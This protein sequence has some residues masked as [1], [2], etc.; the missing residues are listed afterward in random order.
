VNRLAERI[1]RLIAAGGPVPLAD[2][3]HLCL[4][5]PADGYYARLENIGA[6]GDFVT[7]PEISPLFGE[8][9]AVWCVAAWQALGSPARFALVE[10]GP[11]SGALM[12]DVLRASRRFAG[13]HDA[14]A[15]HLVETGPL[16]RERQRLRLSGLHPRIAWVA[17]LAALP[18]EPL[19]FFANEFLDALPV[20]QFVKSGGAWRERCIGLDDKGALAW[21]LGPR[22]ADALPA[23]HETEAEG[24]VFEHAPAREAFA[25]T[26]ARRLAS[27]GGAALLIDYGHA[28][29]GFGD[30]FQ[31]VAGHKFADPL[32][33]PGH[34]DLSSHVDFAAIGRAASAE[35]ATVSPVATQGEF[36]RAMG[37]ET[38]A[39]VLKRA[40]PDKAGTLDAAIARLVGGDAMGRLFKVLAIAGIGTPAIPPFA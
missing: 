17:D 23:G 9:V 29:S 37:I 13:F 25:A 36:L 3:M 5:D 12:E 26:L 40:R 24:A 28:D 22:M 32:A 2:F 20:R 33:A 8:M 30:T 39:Q 21:R 14:A 15:I 34:A 7:A 16:L 18:D 38:R 1:A 31:A 27:G 10:A 4:W 35:G 19:V 6:R 11:G